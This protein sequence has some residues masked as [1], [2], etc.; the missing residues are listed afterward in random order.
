MK[1]EAMVMITIH[2]CRQVSAMMRHS[3]VRPFAF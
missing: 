1:H 3:V 2:G